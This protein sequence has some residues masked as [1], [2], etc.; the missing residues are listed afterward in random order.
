MEYAFD[1]AEK[2][3]NEAL[4]KGVREAVVRIQEKIYESIV[5]DNGILRVCSFSKIKG[6]GLTV[7]TDGVV[8]HSYTTS[9]SRENVLKMVENA[10]ASAKII[11][12]MPKK[13]L[14]PPDVKG[15]RGVYRVVHRVNPLDI[16]VESKI[17]L[18]KELN[19][20]SMS[21]KGIVSAVTKYGFEKDRKIVVSSF[22]SK[23]DIEITAVGIAHT[24]VARYGDVVERHSDSKTFIGGYEGIE[25]FDWVSF[26]N[27][28]DNTVLKVVQA[29]TVS[30][31]VYR[32]VVDSEL[33]G[34]LLHEAFGH[35][36]EGDEV[37]AE[38]SVLKDM[39]G[40][41]VANEN[42]TIVDE[43]LVSGGYPVPYDDDG[44]EKSRTYVVKEGVLVSY[45]HSVLT[46]KKLGHKVTGNARAQDIS[47]NPMV[48]QTNFYMVPGNASIEELFEGIDQGLYLTGKGAG[49]G[50][51]NPALGTFTFGAGPSYLIRKGE[52]TEL[53]RG[54]IVSGNI[55]D[56]LIDVEMIGKDL[57]MIT[58]VFG[59][60]GKE[61]QM[62]RVGIGGPHVRIKKLVVGT[63]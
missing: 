23:I 25:E 27:E 42:V 61:G 18:V 35:P 11:E 30:P 22:G 60:C 31:G 7:Y 62:V 54:V 48:R 50:Q 15:V 19:N 21:K 49:G 5:F 45:L 46:A 44:V 32:V 40:K 3:L 43:G 26:V 24:A 39:L 29:H 51:V 13:A 36:S 57:N 41:S 63:R 34:L 33:I 10:I 17:K 56:V 1:I 2:A 20:L 38:I 52:P 59:G 9:Y 37:Y 4:D 28:I 16:D 55:L 47:F 14:G 58:S 8:G 6:I 12:R 53:V